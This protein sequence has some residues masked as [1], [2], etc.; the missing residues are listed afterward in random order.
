VSLPRPCART[1]RCMVA[2][3][4]AGRRHDL[5]KNIE[6]HG[7]RSH[8][9]A[10]VLDFDATRV[11]DADAPNRDCPGAMARVKAALAALGASRP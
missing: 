10:P 3:L 8:E 1:V 5:Y 7:T 11:P 2:I 4:A 6:R 9:Y